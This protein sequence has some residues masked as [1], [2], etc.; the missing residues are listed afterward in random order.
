MDRRTF[1]KG[2]SAL[3]AGVMVPTLRIRQEYDLHRMVAQF[4]ARP[5]EYLRY[6]LELPFVVEGQAYGTDGRAI[7]RIL[8]SEEDTNHHTTRRL[9][10]VIGVFENMWQEHGRWRRLPQIRRVTHPDKSQPCPQC[11]SDGSLIECPQCEGEGIDCYCCHDWGVLSN[12]ACP[13]CHGV[14]YGNYRSLQLYGDKMI[15]VRF[16]DRLRNIPGVMWC[17]GGP[18]ECDPILYRSD[19]GIEGMVMP[20]IR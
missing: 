7:A 2:A 20:V 8:T 13:V 12:G 10:D 16:D 11:W 19:I 14:P 9:P 18:D 6:Q 15:S 5:G 4:C 17:S 3:A 1:L